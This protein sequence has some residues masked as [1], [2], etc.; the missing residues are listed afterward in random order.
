MRTEKNLA[1]S[2]TGRKWHY[3]CKTCKMELHEAQIK[4]DEMNNYYH[5][6]VVLIDGLL[7][8]VKCGPIIKY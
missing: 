7:Q 5:I 6:K 1:E 4:T 8:E 2:I 3:Y